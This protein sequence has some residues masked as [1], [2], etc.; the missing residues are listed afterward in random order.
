VSW[1][2]RDTIA[3]EGGTGLT[4]IEAPLKVS[5]RCPMSVRSNS[6]SALAPVVAILLT[7]FASTAIDNRALEPLMASQLSPATPVLRSADIRVVMRSADACDVTMTLA[8]EGGGAIDH[9]IEAAE[10]TQ[11]QLT[12]HRGATQMQAPRTIGRTRSLVLESASEYELAYSVRQ[13]TLRDRCPL[14]VP[15]APADGVSRAVRISIELPAGMAPAWTMPAFSWNGSTGTATLA[16]VPAF[17]RA[18]YLPTGESPMWN[19]ATTMDA[20]A[21]FVFVGASGIWLWRRKR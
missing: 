4:L 10:S 15:A 17:V 13:Q 5:F 12:S 7:W 16:H 1:L 8:V 3:L 18:A 21:V 19:V 20:M 14:W 6:R 2:G 9:R 11:V